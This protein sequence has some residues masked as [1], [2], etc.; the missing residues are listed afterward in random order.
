MAA[1]GCWQLSVRAGWQDRQSLSGLL[2]KFSPLHHALVTAG[3][4]GQTCSASLWVQS[5]SCQRPKE[6][7]GAVQQRAAQGLE[8]K[9]ASNAIAMSDSLQSSILLE[10]PFSEYE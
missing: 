10:A 3:R 7:A 1:G 8:A 6:P 9:G 5:A 4:E 2:G